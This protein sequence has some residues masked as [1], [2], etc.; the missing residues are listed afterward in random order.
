VTR[1]CGDRG[2]CIL[3]QPILHAR[4]SPAFGDKRVPRWIPADCFHHFSEAGGGDRFGDAAIAPV[5]CPGAVPDD[6]DCPRGAHG[7]AVLARL[8]LSDSGRAEQQPGHRHRGSFAV[9]QWRCS[10]AGPQTFGSSGS[11]TNLLTATR[12][13][14]VVRSGNQRAAPQ[15]CCSPMSLRK[16]LGVGTLV[17]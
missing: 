2:G 6:R 13:L 1:A 15:Q 16:R 4:A 14:V 12:L 17:V 5:R 7:A 8:P 3:T 10:V 9:Q 11:T